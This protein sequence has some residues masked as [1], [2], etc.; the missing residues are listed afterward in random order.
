MKVSIGKAAKILGV[1]QDTLRRWEAVGKIEA[2][3]T[4]RG[5]QRYDVSKLRSRHAPMVQSNKP[6]IAY[7]RVSEHDQK[8]GSSET[9]RTSCSVLRS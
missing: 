6:T 8:K 1:S 3:R 4:S 5:H 9:G 7:A 2:E